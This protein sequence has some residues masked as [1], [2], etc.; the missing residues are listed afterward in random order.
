MRT[1]K[2]I[3]DHGGGPTALAKALAPELGLPV[4]PVQERVKQWARN[5][6]IPGEYWPAIERLKWGAP[7][8]KG[9]TVRE[10]SQAGEAAKLHRMR[11][12]ER[13]GAAA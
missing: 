9:A 7:G 1:F 4:E 10:M 11:S 13:R 8:T 5:N 3:I 2:D 12:V 6:F